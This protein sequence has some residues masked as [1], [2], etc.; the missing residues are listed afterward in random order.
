MFYGGG[1]ME[2][3][4]LTDAVGERSV[5]IFITMD[6]IV[7][8][9]NV[10]VDMEDILSFEECVFIDGSRISTVTVGGCCFF[11]QQQHQYRHIENQKK[12]KNAE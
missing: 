4:G 10:C 3:L 6:W 8:C 1:D 11:L 2:Q 5:C 12:K 7:R 9:A